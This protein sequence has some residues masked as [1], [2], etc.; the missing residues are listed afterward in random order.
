VQQWASRHFGQDAAHA[1]TN[2]HTTAVEL[3]MSIPTASDEYTH[4]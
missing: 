1:L 2:G 4:G 3:V